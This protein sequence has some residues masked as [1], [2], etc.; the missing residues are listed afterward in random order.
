MYACGFVRRFGVVCVAVSIA[1][2]LGIA[3][4]TAAAD[5]ASKPIP[6]IGPVGAAVEIQGTFKFTEGPATD[7]NGVVFFSD[8]P[9]NKVYKVEPDGRSTVVR[10][11]SNHTNGQMFNAAG[12]IV[13]CERGRVAAY[14]L[15]TGES[16]V[17]ADS[18]G[19][20]PLNGP[21]D[22]VVDASGGVYFTDPS[23]SLEGKSN[24]GVA[25]VYYIATDG[26]LTR[27]IDDVVGPNGVI[28]SPDEKTL[29]VIPF[30]RAEM[31]AYPVLS[32]GKLGEGRVFCTVEQ[33]PGKKNG[34]GDGCAV[35][36]RGNLYI[37]AA[38]GVQVFDPHGN[39]LGTIKTPKGP[40]N[41]EFGG[42]DL[43]TLYVT[44][45]T[46]VY[47]LPME[48]AGHRFPGGR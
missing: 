22:L 40:S 8:V 15:A 36:S 46:S 31:M 42:K 4:M 33:P 48:V 9:A 25:G 1:A 27:V 23:F 12:E 14:S 18:Y 21:N 2:I 3:K 5:D 11:D 24:Q 41:C 10:E 34:G 28:L 19:G 38:T 29:Y 30:L 26:E 35:D 16:R 44:A 45:R 6:G 17:L 47:A 13:S 37:A 20:K 7:K 43:K 39:L 32:P